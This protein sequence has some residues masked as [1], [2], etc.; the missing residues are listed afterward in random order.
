[1]SKYDQC[2]SG[3]E[4]QHKESILQS[5][6]WGT[7]VQR[8]CGFIGMPVS[9]ELSICL[10]SPVGP[11]PILTPTPPLPAHHETLG[12]LLRRNGEFDTSCHQ[13]ENSPSVCWKRTT[14]HP[15]GCFCSPLGTPAGCVRPE[16]NHRNSTH[17][18]HRWPGKNHPG[19][20][21]QSNLSS[22]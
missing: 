8:A 20:S 22:G 3:K 19:C 11:S 6:G 9:G 4:Q 15:G 13:L 10:S 5:C 12:L 21:R 7:A 14:Q 1:M 18:E 17:T 16:D 2:H